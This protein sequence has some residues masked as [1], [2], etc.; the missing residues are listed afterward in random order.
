LSIPCPRAGRAEHRERPNPGEARAWPGRVSGPLSLQPDRRAAQRGDQATNDAGC[1]HREA[2]DDTVVWSF[3]P[4]ML[5]IN[6]GF[7]SDVSEIP[8]V[9]LPLLRGLSI[10]TVSAS[11]YTACVEGNG[12][13]AAG[14]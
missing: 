14:G 8:G 10:E 11:G 3:L 13:T 12:S 1:I 4:A 5:D 2:R 9:A 6:A 7:S